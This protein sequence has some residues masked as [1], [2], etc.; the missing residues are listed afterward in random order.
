M[1]EWLVNLRGRCQV[2]GLG[3]DWRIILK[4]FCTN[5]VCQC[6]SNYNWITLC[7]S[8]TH[9]G[10][11]SHSIYL[12]NTPSWHSIINNLQWLLVSASIR[13]TLK[14]GSLSC[15]PF[16]FNN[17]ISVFL[18]SRLFYLPNNVLTVL[19]RGADKSL[20]R[21]NFRYILFDG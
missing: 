17:E 20:A 6:G 4:I 11:G 7:F 10:C 1:M 16:L 5:T 15:L 9:P 2:G 21:P 12:L 18:V 19:Y 3:K 14:I 8:V 13:A